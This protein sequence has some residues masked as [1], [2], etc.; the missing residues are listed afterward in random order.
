VLGAQERRLCRRCPSRRGVQGA[1]ALPL[2]VITLSP[3]VLA[4]VAPKAE[5]HA[6]PRSFWQGAFRRPLGK[7]WFA[8]EHSITA[9]EAG[10]M[11]ASVLAQSGRSDRLFQRPLIERISLRGRISV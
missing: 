7:S 4:S 3:V 8:V 5:K 11:P 1:G 6:P 10:G 2:P 9:Q